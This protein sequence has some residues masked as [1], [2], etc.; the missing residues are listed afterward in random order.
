MRYRP[1]RFWVV[2]SLS[3]F[4]AWWAFLG[5]TAYRTG[6]DKRIAFFCRDSELLT[7]FF[8]IKFGQFPVPML[9][10]IALWLA[11][12]VSV[13]SY[14]LSARVVRSRRRNGLCPRC[15][16]DLRQSPGRCPECGLPDQV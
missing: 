7:T 2:L 8:S 13:A 15:G 1:S 5:T 6:R 9:I 4:V 10:W 3:A 14:M 16:Y 11:S 12:V